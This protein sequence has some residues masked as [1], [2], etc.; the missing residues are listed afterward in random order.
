MQERPPPHAMP[1]APQ[2]AGSLVR[3]T[4]LCPQAV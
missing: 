1:Q 2:L 4:Q 3:S